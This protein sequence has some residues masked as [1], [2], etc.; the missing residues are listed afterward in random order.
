M[1]RAE[2]HCHVDG[3]LDT[4]L[5]AELG[6]DVELPVV[7]SL[8]DWEL[9]GARVSQLADRVRWLPRVLERHVGRLREQRVRY[10]ELFIS[11]ILFAHDD[12]A[13]LV[14]YVAEL[15]ALATAAAG[16]ELAIE[17]VICVGRGTPERLARQVPRIAALRRAGLVCGVAFA[18]DERHP[19]RPLSRGVDELRALGLGIEIHAG[20]LAGA[21]S[22][23]DA[24]DYG[25]PDRI[26]HG[27]A[28][29]GDPALLDAIATRGIHLELCPSSNLALGAVARLDAHPIG[30]AHAM[31]LPFS[32]NTD[33]PGAFGCS[34]AGEL[35]AVAEMFSL[36]LDAI[37]EATMRAAFRGR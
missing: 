7:R 17:F 30:R 4:A 8:A 29:F 37:F 27:L 5:A 23:R 26:G 11:G 10:A 13:A 32:I 33:D 15:R 21:D 6:F 36:D 9:Y 18:G 28:A 16:P 19:M 25:S 31:G 3:V 14:D 2:L 35:A 34:L 1:R 22:V 24:L 20:E 12:D